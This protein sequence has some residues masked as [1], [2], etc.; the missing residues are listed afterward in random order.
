MREHEV[1][2]REVQNRILLDLQALA[3]LV[4][5]PGESSL[6]AS[7]AFGVTRA[8]I[9]VP[10]VAAAAELTPQKRTPNVAATGYIRFK[11]VL[12]EAF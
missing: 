10:E 3:V 2:A 1:H 6:Q 12:K 5:I 9:S 11:V 7:S 8:S 4:P